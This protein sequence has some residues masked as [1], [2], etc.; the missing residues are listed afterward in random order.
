MDATPRRAE[1]GPSP[2]HVAGAPRDAA[3]RR[4]REAYLA[5]ALIPLGTVD[6]L[7]DVLGPAQAS[8]GDMG[9]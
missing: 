9:P 5:P 2:A 7:L 3:P 8:Y 4:G 1:A 6:E